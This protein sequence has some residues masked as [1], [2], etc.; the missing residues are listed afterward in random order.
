MFNNLS[1]QQLTF[2]NI[3]ETDFFQ[4]LSFLKSLLSS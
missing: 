2:L 1:S 4:P 3:I